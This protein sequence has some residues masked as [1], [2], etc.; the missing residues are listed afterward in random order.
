MTTA[1]TKVPEVYKA[2]AAVL[3]HLSV[4]KNGQ[5]PGNMGGKSYITAVDAS[6]EVKRQFVENNLVFTSNEEVTHHE[7]LVGTDQRKTVVIG[8]TGR[9]EITSLV[10]GSQVTISGGGDGMAIGTSV[11]SN[12]A[13]TNALKNALLRTFLITEQSVE[14]ESRQGADDKPVPAAVAKAAGGVSK[15]AAKPAAKKPATPREQI[16]AQFL[17]GDSPKKTLAQINKL[18]ADVKTETGLDGDP[19]YAEMLVRLNA[20][21]AEA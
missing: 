9:Y 7:V 14:D 15:T 4:D 18:K 19:L 10:D 20:E 3:K 11:A 17:D 12:I 8:L 21:Q 2:M 13:S 5:L 6:A 1:T 16:K